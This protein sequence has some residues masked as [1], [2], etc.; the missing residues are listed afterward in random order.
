MSDIWSH[1]V[2]WDKGYAKGHK[3]GYEQ[4]EEEHKAMC[5]SC[6]HKVSEEV[7]TDFAHN[8]KEKMNAEFPLNYPSTKPFFTLENVRMIID[9]Q[10]KE[11]NNE[12]NHN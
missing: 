7:R 8:L 5:D 12:K 9:E 3:D 4:A 2:E 1:S 10:L 11:Q 6:I